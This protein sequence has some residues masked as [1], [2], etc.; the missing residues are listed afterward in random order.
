MT[1]EQAN[2]KRRLE[3]LALQ[4][5]VNKLTNTVDEFRK[6]TYVD[7]EK[8]A[9][10]RTINRLTQ[11]NKHLKNECERYRDLWKQQG[12]YCKGHT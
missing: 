9:H 12:T 5:E 6:G 11:E 2:E 4:R 1:L 7:A 3:C 10:I 8:A